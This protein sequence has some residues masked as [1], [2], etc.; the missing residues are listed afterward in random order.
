MILQKIWCALFPCYLRF[1]IHLFALL[2]TS[3]RNNAKRRLWL[4]FLEWYDLFFSLLW[5]FSFPRSLVGK[6]YLWKI[7][8][9]TPPWIMNSSFCFIRSLFWMEYTHYSS[10]KVTAVLLEKVCNQPSGNVK[11]SSV[12]FCVNI[13][14]KSGLYLQTEPLDYRLHMCITACLWIFHF[15]SLFL[16]SN[17]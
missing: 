2:P 5:K 11:R 1:E 3:F 9:I 8:G 7:F 15:E 13:N 4:C 14:I 16:F 12:I 17:L 6:F 10:K